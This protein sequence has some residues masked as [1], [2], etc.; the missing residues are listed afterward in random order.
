[1]TTLEKIR[2]EI[3]QIKPYDLPCDKRTPQNMLDMVLEIIDKYAEQEPTD[4]W[5]NGYDMAWEEAKVFYEQEPC[6][7]AVSR[8]ELL[9]AI[10]TWDKFGCDADTKLVPYKD[11]YIPYI[12]YDDVVKCIKG[13]P[14]V[15]PKPIECEDAVSRQA[16]KE[17][18]CRICM[19]TN[20]CYRSKENCE[21]LKLFD[22]LPSVQPK[23]T[24]HWEMCED[25]DGLYGV[26]DVCGQDA[27]FSHYGKAYDFCPN[28]GCRMVEPQESEVK[29]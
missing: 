6:E 12:H 15:Q 3:E 22:K 20:V 28:C 29:E 7:D 25:A 2:A 4:E 18:Y 27:D 9:K 26:C 16:V 17:L 5:Q 14:S 19:E 1:M 23:K 8:E 11:H 10:D 24:G 13:M 21:D